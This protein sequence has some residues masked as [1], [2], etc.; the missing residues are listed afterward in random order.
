MIIGED[1]KTIA[2]EFRS[3][4]KSGPLLSSHHKRMIDLY[5]DQWIAIYDGRVEAHG[6]DYGELL[7]QI[8]RRKIPRRL[9]VLRYITRKRKSMI[10]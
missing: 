4:C 3:F 10:L 2:E 8:D 6:N 5:P 7:S 1:F 9:T